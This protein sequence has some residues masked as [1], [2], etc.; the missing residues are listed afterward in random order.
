MHGLIF[1]TSVWLLAESTRLLPF[2]SQTIISTHFHPCVGLHLSMANQCAI[3]IQDTILASPQLKL[4]RC[5]KLAHQIQYK[6]PVLAPQKSLRT[7]HCNKTVA[8][9]EQPYPQLRRSL[10]HRL[11]TWWYSQPQHS[12]TKLHDPYQRTLLPYKASSSA[13]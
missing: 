10:H 4:I 5:H 11:H 12:Q 3:L 8:L 7:P 13:T 2:L 6:G 1:E 9:F